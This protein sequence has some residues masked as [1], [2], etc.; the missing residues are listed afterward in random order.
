MLQGRKKAFIAT[1]DTF[2]KVSYTH[3]P[4]ILRKMQKK[5]MEITKIIV[6]KYKK[7]YVCDDRISQ[8]LYTHKWIN[9][10]SSSFYFKTLG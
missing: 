10:L 3:W 8:N 1:D 7:I 6:K 4:H 5:H 2:S 9:F